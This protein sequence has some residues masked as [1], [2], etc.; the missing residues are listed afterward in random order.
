VPVFRAIK[1]CDLPERV[2]TPLPALIAA[3]EAAFTRYEEKL[4]A[5]SS[6]HL[7]PAA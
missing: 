7:R 4:L 5:Q 1:H 3:V 2:Y 6:D